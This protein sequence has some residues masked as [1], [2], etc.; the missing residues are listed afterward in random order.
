MRKIENFVNLIF[1]CRIAYIISL[2]NKN[3]ISKDIIYAMGLLHDIGRC[4][5]YQTEVEHDVAGAELAITIMND[6]GYSKYEIDM[7]MDVIL[8][9]RNS[10]VKNNLCKI[11]Y[12]A[13]KLSRQCFKC[14]VQRDCYWDEI[15]K[16]K[17]LIY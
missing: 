9:H 5:S 7:I 1:N 13:D 12:K 17:I 3:D 10:S 6:V 11:L 15:R 8:N 16:N 4:Q 14:C 2:E